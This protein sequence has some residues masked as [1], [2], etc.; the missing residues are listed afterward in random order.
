MR[1]LPAPNRYGI[2]TKS[3]RSSSRKSFSKSS[4]FM[5][6]DDYAVPGPGTYKPSV[7]HLSRDITLKG[8]LPESTLKPMPSPADYK[9]VDPHATV[10]RGITMKVKWREAR[11][12][13]HQLAQC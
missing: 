2:Y 3:A 6:V 12:Q 4:R 5:N 10:A 7:S 13:Y 11:I 9:I 1:E 8:R